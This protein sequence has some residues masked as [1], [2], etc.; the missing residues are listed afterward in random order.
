MT[1]E[2]AVMNKHGIALAAD[3]AVTVSAGGEA[4]IFTSANKIFSLSKF[5]PVAVMIYGNAELLGLPW[6]TTV[7]RYRSQLGEAAFAS[8]E[9]YVDDFFGFLQSE[10]DLFPEATQLDYVEGTVGDLFEAVANEIRRQADDAIEDRGSIDERDIS[11]I[12]EK[13]ILDIHGLWEAQPPLPYTSAEHAAKVESLYTDAFQEL[14][15]HHFERLPLGSDLTEKLLELASWLLTRVPPWDMPFVTGVVIAGFGQSDIFPSFIETMVDGLAAA[16]VI[17]W[18]TREQGITRRDDAY[19]GAFAQA[20]MVGRFMEGVD[21][22]YQ[23]VLM[24]SISQ[25]MDG[26]TDVILKASKVRSTSKLKDELSAARERMLDEYADDLAMYRHESFVR[27]VIG[28]VRS[29]PV[30]ELAHMAESLVNLTSFKR[31][32]SMEAES[33]SGPIDVAV[34]S[35]GDGFIWIK[36]KHYFQPEK[37]PHFQANYYRG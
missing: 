8:L 12:V 4:K 6:E 36:R 1:A 18:R 33:V 22:E 24:R 32:V 27:G 28:V 16:E 5:E 11:A 2:V 17:A 37:N 13:E 30:G 26:Y 14:A 3:S 23:S 25:L 29:L 31:R 7:K 34:I 10:G 9:E 20:E 35:R 15:R 21:P 19:V